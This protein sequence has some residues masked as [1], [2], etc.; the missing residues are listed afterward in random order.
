L[1]FVNNGSGSDIFK[2][3]HKSCYCQS[4]MSFQLQR[5]L[6][7][8][9]FTDRHAILGVSV[10][11]EEKSIRT[12][13]QAIAR[14]LHPDS[15]NWKTDADRQL[16]V[17]LFSRLVTH[18]YGQLSKS[19][20]L[21]EQTIMLELLGKRLVE[22]SSQIQ[23][24]DPICQQL[25]QSGTDFEQVYEQ[26]LV[27]LA[28]QQFTDLAKSEQIVN[29][30]SELNMV[31]LLRRQLQSVRSTPPTAPAGA[32]PGTSA[33]TTPTAAKESSSG[34]IAKATSV[35]GALRRAEDRMSRQNWVQAVQELREAIISEP[36]NAN[37]HALLGMV[38]LRQ[39]QMTMAKISINKA[40]QLAP[41]DPKVLQAK[42]EFDQ[43]SNP[44]T[45]AKTTA[46]K[47][48][49]GLFGLFGGKK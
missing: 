47:P 32:A 49:E 41:K 42:K 15:G 7:Q 28:T 11:A 40:I 30:I 3:P 14:S 12:R 46:A 19:S 48:R 4:I 13:Y 26:M 34:D 9:D 2:T 16:A 45:S 25:Y 10:N 31:Y 39:K 8:F 20:Q 35:E 23:I 17:R 36:N 27:E 37:A 18:A 5:G 24:I 22:Q 44:A 43:A 38:Y 1:E 29:Q 21:Q 6:F 33:G